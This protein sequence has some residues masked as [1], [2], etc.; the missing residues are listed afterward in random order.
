[1]E[2]WRRFCLVCS[3]VSGVSCGK[4]SP[5]YCAELRFLHDQ[6][7]RVKKAQ[8][9]VSRSPTGGSQNTKKNVDIL[10]IYGVVSFRR[11]ITD[12]YFTVVIDTLVFHQGPRIPA[13]RNRG[14]FEVCVWHARTLS[15]LERIYPCEVFGFF[16]RRTYF[17]ILYGIRTR[18]GSKRSRNQLTISRQSCDSACFAPLL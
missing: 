7:L 1:M 4:D 2:Q 15:D 8:R 5:A 13:T 18:Q 11:K 17:L 6:A 9:S 14:H 16:E 12:V 3:C 10:V